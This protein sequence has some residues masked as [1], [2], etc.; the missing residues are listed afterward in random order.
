[1]WYDAPLPQRAPAGGLIDP[2]DGRFYTGGEFTPFYVPRP[3]MPQVDEADYLELLSHAAFAGVDV[4]SGLVEPD[5][6]I[7]H[8]RIDR[9]HA[10]MMP[11]EVRRKPILTSRGGFILD[12]NH[13][14]MLH[15]LEGSP[16]HTLRFALDFEDAVKLLFDFP[17]TYTLARHAETN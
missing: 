3:L 13:R 5:L 16:I 4:V 7:A 6:L 12:G 8:Q 15:K 9:I 14:W 11:E 17:K 1:M 2:L 10:E